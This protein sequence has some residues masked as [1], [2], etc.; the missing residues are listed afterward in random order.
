MCRQPV[1][2]HLALRH[3]AVRLRSE[4]RWRL[5]RTVGVGVQLMI[6]RV[7][8]QS[9]CDCADNDETL[10]DAVSHDLTRLYR[11]AETEDYDDVVMVLNRDG[12]DKW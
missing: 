6:E 11:A 7:D 2:Q 12:D 1:Q 3:C 9:V 4:A 5:L 10:H 8:L